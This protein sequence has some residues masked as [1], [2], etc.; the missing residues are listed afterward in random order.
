MT[1][2]FMYILLQILTH[3]KL[4]AYLRTIQLSML[5]RRLLQYWEPFYVLRYIPAEHYF[6]ELEKMGVLFL[7]DEFRGKNHRP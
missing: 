1:I 5:S 6:N 7:V 2:S 4:F 3:G